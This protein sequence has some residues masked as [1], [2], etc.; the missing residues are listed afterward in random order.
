MDKVVFLDRDGTINVDTGYISDP[1]GIELFKGVGEAIKKLK[2]ANYKTLIVT[3]QSG[4]GRG[5]FKEA[6]LEKVNNKILSLL[7]EQGATID[8]IYFCPHKPEVNCNCRK[9]ETGMIEEAKK[10]FN[11]DMKKSFV[12]GD[13]VADISLGE[14]AGLNTI[15]VL[16]GEGEKHKNNVKADFIADDLKEA[17][18]FILH[19]Y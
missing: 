11:I 8:R 3:N 16:T 4:I 19:N 18:N 13:K 5:Y 10:D 9:P 1:H 2:D 6:D 7:N 12:I 17:V 15:L 14:N